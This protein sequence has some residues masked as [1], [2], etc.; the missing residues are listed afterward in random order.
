MVAKPKLSVRRSVDKFLLSSQCVRF[1][2]GSTH[3]IIIAMFLMGGMFMDSAAFGRASSPTGE[4][5]L[6]YVTIVDTHDGELTPGATIVIED[7]KIT[8]IVRSGKIDVAANAQHIDGKGRFVVPGFWDMHAHPFNNANL[9]DNLT[10]M[11]TY[12]ITGVRQ[13]TGSPQLLEARKEGKLIPSTPAPELLALPGDLL[14]PTNAGTPEAAV[15]E[16]QKQKK[17]GA[18]FIKTIQVSPDAF[19]ASLAEANRQGFAVRRT[20]L[21]R[22]LR[23]QGIRSRYACDRTSWRR[24]RNARRLLLG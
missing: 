3:L 10:L 23:N 4:L 14:L 16:V 7:G 22:R 19:F 11:L 17:E 2:F 15:A 1:R 5:I 8:K 24:R 13:M 12:G 20:S 21:A 6:S 18:D 9:A